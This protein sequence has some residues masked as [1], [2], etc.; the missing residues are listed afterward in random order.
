[1]DITIKL[2]SEEPIPGYEPLTMLVERNETVPL[3][4]F[5]GLNYLPVNIN[6]PKSRWWKRSEEPAPKTQKAVELKSDKGKVVGIVYRELADLAPLILSYIGYKNGPNFQLAV[7]ELFPG[8]VIDQKPTKEE[9]LTHIKAALATG[10]LNFTKVQEDYTKVALISEATLL[11]VTVETEINGENFRYFV[12]TEK[13]IEAITN[14]NG[15][16]YMS[17]ENTAD[18]VIYTLEY[19]VPDRTRR[20]YANIFLLVEPNGYVLY[21][22]EDNKVWIFE[23]GD[24]ENLSAV[25]VQL[26]PEQN[27]CISLV[28]GDKNIHSFISLYFPC[29]KTVEVR[30]PKQEYTVEGL[31]QLGLEMGIKSGLT[32]KKAQIEQTIM[33]AILSLPAFQEEPLLLI[34]RKSSLFSRASYQL[35]DNISQKIIEGK[36]ALA[37]AART[38][39]DLLH[40]SDNPV[41]PFPLE[42]MLNTVYCFCD[43]PDFS[44]LQ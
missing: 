1:M 10:T 5:L 7:Q 15:Y 35:P 3:S 17:C 18:R 8:Y 9:Y 32:G 19:P 42:E 24:I 39:G 22:T 4:V 27:R 16:P 20:L 38:Q 2:Y 25:L 23:P 34:E 31:K 29:T 14:K 11:S 44:L 37:I 41:N 40:C 30:M 13:V 43:I 6:T 12:A 28:R 26:A 33:E 21:S 36:E